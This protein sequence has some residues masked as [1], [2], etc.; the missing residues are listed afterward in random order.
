MDIDTRVVLI[1]QYEQYP[2]D[3]LILGSVYTPILT[4]GGRKKTLDYKNVLLLM[5]ILKIH[6]PPRW[7]TYYSP[8]ETD[9]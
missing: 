2:P 8:C 4:I 7:V 3:T 5:S 1:A 9:H 6:H